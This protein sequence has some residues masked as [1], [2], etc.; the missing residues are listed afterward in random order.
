[1]KF[2]RINMPTQIPQKF[3]HNNETHKETLLKFIALL[4]ILIV[5]FLYMSWKYDASTGLAVTL[6]TWSFFVLCTPIADGGFILAFPIRLLFGIKM[7]I[8]Q[9]ILWFVA[10]GINLIMIFYSPASYDLSFLT[11][12]LKT[13]ITEPYPYWSIL[14]L[15]ALG[16]FLS[17]I[18]GDEMMDVTQH[19]HRKQHHKY[20]SRYRTLLTLGFTL[21][22]VVSYYHLLS[23]L[24]ITIVE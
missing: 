11:N 8:T 1:M 16:T 21:L 5:Y 18:F 13:I 17:I 10:I 3:H 9:T 23:N 12:L 14:I 4:A 19:R 24:H 7:S 2:E 20:G 22:I 15:S 6:L